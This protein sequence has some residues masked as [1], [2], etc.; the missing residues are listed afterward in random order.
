MH[1]FS[2]APDAADLNAMSKCSQDGSATPWPTADLLMQDNYRVGVWQPSKELA[3][4]VAQTL[5]SVDGMERQ[6]QRML[7]M[8]DAQGNPTGEEAVIARPRS[9]VVCG[10]LTE[11]VTPNGMNEDRFRSFELYRRHL[12]APDVIT[13]DELYERAKLIVEL[14]MEA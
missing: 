1:A 11:F 2:K 8:K 6:F 4:A 13:F 9:V 5:M 10:S 14:A 7:I 3:G 12:V